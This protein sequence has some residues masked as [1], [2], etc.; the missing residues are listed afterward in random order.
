VLGAVGYV[1]W[2]TAQDLIK[3]SP[4]PFFPGGSASALEAEA[5]L[6]AP[7]GGPFSVRALVEYS[8]TSY[9][10]KAGGAYT[11]SGA[12]DAYLGFRLMARAEY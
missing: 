11:A 9:T 3:G 7:L 6:S 2:T 10:L 8:R 4:D 5:G 1:D 12:T